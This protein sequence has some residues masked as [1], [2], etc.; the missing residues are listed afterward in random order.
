MLEIEFSNNNETCW[1]DFRDQEAFKYLLDCG[2]MM[3]N[4]RI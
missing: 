2:W 1:V 4:W 3:T